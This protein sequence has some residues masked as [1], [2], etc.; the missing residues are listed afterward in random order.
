MLLN[1]FLLCGLFYWGFE[2]RILGNFTMQQ[3]RL[4]NFGGPG[5]AKSNELASIVVSLLPVFVGLMAFVN[6][7]EKFVGAF[8]ILSGDQLNDAYAE[9]R[10]IFGPHCF[11]YNHSSCGFR[12]SA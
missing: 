2:S 5:C 1:W 3:G 10:W 6:W 4:E 8:A 11:R 9:S 7:R 12:S